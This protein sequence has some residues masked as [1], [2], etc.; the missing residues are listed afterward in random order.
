[1]HAAEGDAYM[2]VSTENWLLV[3]A[4]TASGVSNTI[5]ESAHKQGARMFQCFTASV[6]ST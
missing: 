6:R 5:T 3:K 2:S 4:W 1:M